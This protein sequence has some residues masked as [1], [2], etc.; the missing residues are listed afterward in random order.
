VQWR[1]KV[2]F[3]NEIKK[4]MEVAHLAKEVRLERDNVLALIRQDAQEFG[5]DEKELLDW[6]NV[7][8]VLKTE[9]NEDVITLNPEGHKQMLLFI[10]ED[11]AK[12]FAVW[13]EQHTNKKAVV[14]KSRNTYPFKLDCLLTIKGAGYPLWYG[15]YVAQ[16]KILEHY[17]MKATGLI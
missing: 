17:A 3:F 1:N 14:K 11:E 12:E 10:T 6:P 15:T 13:L 9:D 7:P 4:K 16:A 5:H 8:F 2:K